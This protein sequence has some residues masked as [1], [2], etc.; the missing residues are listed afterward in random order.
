MPDVYKIFICV[1]RLPGQ[2]NILPSSQCVEINKNIGLF[3]KN[4]IYIF[5]RPGINFWLM[6]K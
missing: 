1:P 2:T 3:K 5:W 4:D 6:W